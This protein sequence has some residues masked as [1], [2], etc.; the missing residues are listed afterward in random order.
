MLYRTRPYGRTA[1]VN[2]PSFFFFVLRVVI[3]HTE[4]Y[5]AL[6]MRMRGVHVGDD[7]M[8]VARRG[9][10]LTWERWHHGIPPREH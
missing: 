6:R 10:G 7:G 8:P 5:N 1:V 9:A 4:T 3:G 2:V